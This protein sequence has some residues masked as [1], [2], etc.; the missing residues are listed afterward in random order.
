MKKLYLQPSETNI[1]DC[2]YKDSIGRNHDIFSFI[3]ILNAIDDNFSIALDSYWGSGKTFFVKQVKMILDATSEKSY[4]DV[5]GKEQILEIW[6][7]LSNNQKFKSYATIYY[8]TW[9]NDNDDDPI[10][11]LIY[12]IVCDT[13]IEKGLKE[14]INFSDILEVAGRFTCAVAGFNPNEIA[15]PLKKQDF[16]GVIRERQDIDSRIED[17]FEKIIPEGCDRLLIIIDELDR[18]SP[19]FAVKLLERIKHYF[20]NDRITF[21]FSVNLSELQISVRNFYG[22]EFNASRYL[23]RFFDLRVS[24]PPINMDRFIMYAADLT[25]CFSHPDIIK[26]VIKTQNMQMRECLKYISTMRLMQGFLSSNDYFP[27]ENPT[28]YAKFF[29]VQFLIPV[30]VSE[31]ICNIFLYNRFI[32]ENDWSLLDYY[33][34]RIDICSDEYYHI[35]RLLLEIPSDDSIKNKKMFVNNLENYYNALMKETKEVKVG[36][37]LITSTTRSLFW[38]SISLLSDKTSLDEL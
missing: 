31:R 26:S 8:D 1:R 28:G 22:N 11:S 7:S 15:T 38:E 21:V 4:T 27:V 29:L 17:F 37:C 34:K 20:T 6:K 3:R 9:K 30:L 14:S 10:Y 2:F 25:S 35:C 33:S 24:L 16:L 13:R 36:K 18:C 5:E 19:T 32:N 23:D 12:Q